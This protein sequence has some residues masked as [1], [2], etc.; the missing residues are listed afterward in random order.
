MSTAQLTTLRPTS[1]GLGCG[2]AAPS[3]LSLAPISV[4]PDP[5]EAAP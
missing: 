2:D 5:E 1:A 4:H 3:T